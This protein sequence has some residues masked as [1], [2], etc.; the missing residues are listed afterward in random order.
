M[1]TDSEASRKGYAISQEKI[2]DWERY[3]EE[4]LPTA[5][6]TIEDHD[7]EV[8]VGIPDPEV[9]EGDWDHS[10]TV[11][12]EFPSVE[13]AQSCYTDPTYEQV[14]QIRIETSEYANAIICPEFSPE[15]L[16]G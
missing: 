8:I 5:S 3:M 6:E 11:V 4:Y 7:G 14:K 15:D 9:V 10:L 2:D 16:P 12:V 1:S 13:D